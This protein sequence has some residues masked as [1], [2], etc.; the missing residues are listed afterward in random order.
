MSTVDHYTALGVLPTASDLDIRTTYK[1][2]ALAYHPDRNTEDGHLFKEI[3]AAYS[4]LGCIDKRR[5]YDAQR[6]AAASAYRGE[7]AS[8]GAA[9]YQR[10]PTA[11]ASDEEDVGAVRERASVDAAKVFFFHLPPSTPPPPTPFVSSNNNTHTKM[12]H[13]EPI[14]AYM[15]IGREKDAFEEMLSADRRRA[16]DRRARGGLQQRLD[17]AKQ[18]CAEDAAACAERRRHRDEEAAAARTAAE[19]GRQRA[20]REAKA[21]WEAEVARMQAKADAATRGCAAAEATAERVRR[22]EAA[23]EEARQQRVAALVR[24]HEAELEAQKDSVRLAEYVGRDTASL[25]LGEI[26]DLRS[27]LD[28][29]RARLDSEVQRRR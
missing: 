14:S 12:R 27:L 1:R 19:A 6:S 26:D 17:A 18:R 24:Q 21:E 29:Y 16:A 13:R 10:R 25:S 5:E 2:L 8:A 15:F 20:A 7:A 11:D 9:G 4:V 23:E 22:E 3:A 28:A